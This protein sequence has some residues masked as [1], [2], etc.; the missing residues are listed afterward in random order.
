MSELTLTCKRA[1]RNGKVN[2]V[3]RFGT[4]TLHR[5]KLDLMDDAAC[6]AFVNRVADGRAGIDAAART[7]LRQ[8]LADAAAD[9]VESAGGS[10]Q[11]ETILDLVKQSGAE[12]FHDADRAFAFVPTGSHKETHALTG[13]TFKRWLQRLFYAQTGGSAPS[14]EAITAAL[15]VL[16]GRALFDGPEMPTAVRVA[17][18]G[19]NIFIDLADDRWRAAQVDS[20]GWRIVANCPVRFL[21]PRGVLALP[22]PRAGGSV[23]ALR[24]LVN[25]PDDD[26]WALLLA[27]IV[28]AL[29]PD[30][31][32]PILTVSGEQGS[33]KSTLSRIVRA[34]IDPNAAALR[35]EPREGRDLSIAA[36]N[37]WVLGFDNVSGLRPWLSDAF[38]RLATGGGFSTRTLYSD[39]EET[40]FDAMR[41]VM[42]NGIGDIAE[43][44]DLLD[45]AVR[46]MLPT[47]PES[48]RRTERELWAAFN[49]A[50]PGILGS[51]LDAV[52]A[53]TRNLPTVRIPNPPRMADF[54]HAA[55]AAELAL[56]LRPGQFLTAY[57]GNR[58]AAHD[59]AIESTSV[60]PVIV[61]LMADCTEW[62]GTAAELLVELGNDRHTSEQQ[63][64][65]ADWP[66]SA[67]QLGADLRRLAPNLRAVGIE[68]HMPDRRTGRGRRRIIVLEKAG[69]QWSAC[70]A[71]AAGGPDGAEKADSGV[72]FADHAAQ[73]GDRPDTMVRT[74]GDENGPGGTETGFAD[75]ADHADHVGPAMTEFDV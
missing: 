23:D 18:H 74:D 6:N 71:C 8:Q 31:P 32:Y 75:H 53:V 34:L 22:E 33:C 63:R 58:A 2:A 48:A 60:G 36:A 38:C 59:L 41:P 73:V 67:R 52:S 9:V 28:A 20:A 19:D 26:S 69:A 66:K 64:R 15:G 5:G 42:L 35:A 14:T 39:D 1:G 61:G 45:R 25:V 56:G 65:Q 62:S 68:V 13:K 3:V 44:S 30:G 37:G 43:R 46:L 24:E 70:A 40:I 11:A 21:R 54:A 51:L 57:R 7:A 12:L 27:W 50:A 29:R 17:E 49:S 55:H 10:N 16:Q 4:E 47:I 72:L